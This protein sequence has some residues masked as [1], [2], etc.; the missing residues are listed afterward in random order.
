[1]VA[2]GVTP[3]SS[4]GLPRVAAWRVSAG[5]SVAVVLLLCLSV[6]IGEIT[7]QKRGDRVRVL[8]GSAL[9]AAPGG[10]VVG[11][12]SRA[13]EAP[14]EMVQGSAVRLK[15]NGFVS[16]QDVRLESSGARA[17]M[18]AANG[19]GDAGGT[20]RTGRGEKEPALATLQRGAVVFPGSKAESYFAVSRTIWVDKSRLTKFTGPGA[21]KAADRP[22]VAVKVN[23]QTPEPRP[24]NPGTV[25]S[26]AAPSPLPVAP[27]AQSRAPKA[28]GA[29]P[30]M[31]VF[32]ATQLRSGPSG[33]G[34]FSLPAGTVV[35]PLVSEGSWTRIRVEGWVSTA[36][37]AA[38]DA[39]S[40]AGISAAD[41]RADPEGMK[42]RI[43]RWTVENL[44]Y[45]LGDGL[46]RE[47]NG[48]PYLLAR[49][50]GTERA[51]LYLAVPD[52]LVERARALAPLSTINITARVRSGRSQPGGVPILD[53]VEL[54]RR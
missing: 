8:A 37:L 25:P 52:S 35:T 30:A 27:S 19:R 18:G 13:F 6:P 53:L 23:A 11:V 43:V 24:A 29:I 22:S 17:L 2:A 14:V 36:E 5:A 50:P 7:A 21:E 42:G 4:A 3:V 10:Q 48:E 51:I 26:P 16:E 9:R 39:R 47:L 20:V 54:L 46:R 31:Q 34:L 28:A 41:L 40:S 44:S 1:M 12:M 49:G 45:Q 15:L 32:A 38:L 33:N